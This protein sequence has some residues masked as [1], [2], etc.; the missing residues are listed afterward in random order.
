MQIEAMAK[1]ALFCKFWF[2][3]WHVWFAN[4]CNVRGDSS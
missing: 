2:V 1:I 4:M 3:R